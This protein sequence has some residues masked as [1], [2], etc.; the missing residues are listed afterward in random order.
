[1]CKVKFFETYSLDELEKQINQWTAENVECAV[2]DIKY[3]VTFSC[4]TK[5]SIAASPTEKPYTAMVF[6]E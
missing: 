4:S 6:Y 1:M 2:R 3:R 5:H